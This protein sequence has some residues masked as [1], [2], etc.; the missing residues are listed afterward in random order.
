MLIPCAVGHN[1]SSSALFFER[2]VEELNPEV[3]EFGFTDTPAVRLRQFGF[4]AGAPC[5]GVGGA[6][7]AEWK[8]T[9]RIGGPFNRS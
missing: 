2:G 8:A 9:P 7:Q 6:R 5:G 1:E 4:R 3:M